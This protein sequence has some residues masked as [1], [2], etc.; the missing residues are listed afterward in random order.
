MLLVVYILSHLLVVP[1]RGTW[2]CGGS[3]RGVRP[4]PRPLVPGVSWDPWEERGVGVTGWVWLAQNER[5]SEG[6]VAVSWNP[7]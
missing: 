3:G 6:E 2:V 7:L 5:V 4:V 1:G